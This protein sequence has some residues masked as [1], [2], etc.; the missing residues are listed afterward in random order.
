MSMSEMKFAVAVLTVY[1][2]LHDMWNGLLCH[3]IG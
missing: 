2:A 3:N 1:T